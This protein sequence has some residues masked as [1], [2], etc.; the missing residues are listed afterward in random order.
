M[1]NSQELTWLLKRIKKTEKRLN[2]LMK[3]NIFRFRY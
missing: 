1:K 3:P 2:F